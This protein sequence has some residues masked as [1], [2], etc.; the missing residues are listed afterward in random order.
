[1]GSEKMTELVPPLVP[2][3]TVPT[4]VPPLEAWSMTS[5]SLPLPMRLTFTNSVV[6]L[7]LAFP[8][9]TMALLLVFV[10]WVVLTTELAQFR[11]VTISSRLQ[12][13][14]P[15]ASL[16]PSL[17]A[18]RLARNSRVCPLLTSSIGMTNVTLAFGILTCT[19]WC[20]V[21][22]TWG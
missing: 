10:V 15:K 13:A 5:I 17:R 8:V 21:P 6:F 2:L 19:R 11:P 18:R 9:R 4:T 16:L 12:R 7:T 1:M 20:R 14:L 22:R 3:T